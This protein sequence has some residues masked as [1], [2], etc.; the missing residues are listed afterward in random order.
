MLYFVIERFKSPDAAVAVYQRFAERGRMLPEGLNYLDSWVEKDLN[1]CFQLM[2]TN[3]PELFD[4]WISNW[5]DL[6]EFEVIEVMKSAAAAA[7][8][9]GTQEKN[10]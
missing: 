8:V 6:V 2:E 4:E 1:R 3:D 9:L 7:E 5:S 10:N